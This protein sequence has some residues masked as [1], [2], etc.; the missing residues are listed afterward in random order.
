MTGISKI[1]LSDRYDC[2]KYVALVP[3]GGEFEATSYNAD[4]TV[5]CR[6]DHNCQAERYEY[7][8]AGRM[9]KVFDRD[10]NLL[11]ENSY[12]VVVQSF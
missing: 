12:N 6:F 9:V 5:Y 7:D 2:P 11:K 8:S 4:G 1:R 3:A 10:G